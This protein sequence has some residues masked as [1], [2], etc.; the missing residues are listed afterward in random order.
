MKIELKEAARKMRKDE[1]MSVRKIAERLM[2]S[3]GSVSKWV[4]DVELTDQQKIELG[5][6]GFEKGDNYRQSVKDSFRNRRKEQQ[7]IG[8]NRAKIEDNTYAFGCSLFW[9]EGDK[10]KNQMTFTNSDKNMIKLFFT[11]IK[12]KFNVKD[13]EWRISFNCYLNDGMSIEDIG[14]FWTNFLSL[15]KS[16]LRKATIKSKYY[17]NT[18]KQKH[19]YGIC[20]IR[21]NRTDIVQQI[22]GSIK[23]Y[24]GINDED[25][26]IL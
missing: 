2:V 3:R 8:R 24:A 20:R 9:A 14:D 18:S 5:T 25:L 22:Y 1:G 26:W 15:P 4:R 10:S 13:E 6:I 17:N 11:F 12:S 23:E 21:L 16:C 7:L 19:P